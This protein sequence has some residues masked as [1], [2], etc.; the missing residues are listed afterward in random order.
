[1]GAGHATGLLVT[2]LLL[3]TSVARA[4]NGSFYVG[5]GV[6]RDKVTG[7]GNGSFPDIDGSS[8]KVYLGV[9]PVSVFA[10]E[11]DYLDLGGSRTSTL[12]IT[13]N[14]SNADAFAGYAVGF[15]PIP[16]PFLDVFGKAG[17]ARWKLNGNTL[18]SLTGPAALSAS[19]T[20]FAW[21]VGTQIHF[22]NLGA[23][24]EYEN[25]DIL[26]TGGAHIVSLELF[27]NIR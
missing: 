14:H 5:S 2:A 15:L 24:L 10:I 22:G 27:V 23:R 9:R 11:A 3:G 4:D 17:L 16:L 6:S 18:T 25:V 20:D 19:G 21:G 1:M 12:L 13:G 8:W 26:N 7:I